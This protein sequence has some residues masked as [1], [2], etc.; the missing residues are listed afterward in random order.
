VASI[1]RTFNMIIEMVMKKWKKT[2]MF[3]YQP[4]ECFFEQAGGSIFLLFYDTVL[5]SFFMFSQSVEYVYMLIKISWG[6]F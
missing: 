1:D 2:L 3:T 4:I 6:K 5:L